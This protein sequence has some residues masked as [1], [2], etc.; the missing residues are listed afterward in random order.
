[1]EEIR[2]CI[3]TRLLG[4]SAANFAPQPK[5]KGRIIPAP[6]VRARNKSVGALT[7]AAARTQAGKQSPILPQMSAG[8]LAGMPA[9]SLSH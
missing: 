9:T 3:H 8:Q 7:A 5:V 2:T 4:Q 6:M 1:M